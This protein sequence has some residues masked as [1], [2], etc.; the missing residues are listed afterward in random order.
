MW[1]TCVI[2]DRHKGILQSI[3]EIKDGSKSVTELHCG[4]ILRAGDTLG[5][6]KQTSTIN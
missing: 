4:Q 1:R 6:S 3:N 5:T 2:H